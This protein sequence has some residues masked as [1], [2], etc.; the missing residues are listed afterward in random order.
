[1]STWLVYSYDPPP[2]TISGA[3]YILVPHNVFAIIVDDDRTLESP[4]SVNL[5]KLSSFDEANKMFA[6]FA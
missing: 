2:K 1:M 5:T 6:G 3:T 4:K